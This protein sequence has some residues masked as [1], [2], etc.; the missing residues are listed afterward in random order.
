MEDLMHN[1]ITQQA[2]QQP[3][4]NGED[5]R[6]KPPKTLRD[7]IDVHIEEQQEC[8]G[9]MSERLAALR[10]VATQGRNTLGKGSGDEYISAERLASAKQG[11]Y[12]APLDAA[13]AFSMSR[14]HPRPMWQQQASAAQ[15]MDKKRDPL[16]R[17]QQLE[18]EVQALVG[19]AMS[20]E[21]QRNPYQ[22]MQDQLATQAV[23]MTDPKKAA[24]DRL[25]K[26]LGPADGSGRLPIAAPAV[27]A[28]VAPGSQQPAPVGPMAV[29]NPMVQQNMDP[30]LM[31]RL[32]GLG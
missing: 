13:I 19:M 23:A 29:Q 14:R 7:L 24:D 11:N 26:L 31:A 8:L 6:F 16:G 18:T 15:T 22:A 5:L 20:Q 1:M 25:A 17:Y 21:G 32:Q 4:N 9:I 27:Q 2:Y 30:Q 28:G 10:S 12:S 3:P